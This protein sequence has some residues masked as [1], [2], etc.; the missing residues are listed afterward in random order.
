M[1]G[2]ARATALRLRARHPDAAALDAVEQGLADDDEL[3]QLA[4]LEALDAVPVPLR[5]GMA[6]SF[7]THPL[8]AFRITAA[9][10]LVGARQQLSERRR[11]D[12]AAALDEYIAVQAFNGDRAEGPF[13]RGNLLAADGRFDEA[14]AAF[15]A[16][17]EREPAFGPAHANLADLYR[18]QG[19]E[20]DAEAA[21]RRGLSANADDPALHFALGLSLVRSGRLDDALAEL[22]RAAV[23]ADEPRY[24]YAH[25]IALGS[26]G[27]M[28]QA[29]DV[30]TE[31]ARRFPG[32]APTLFALAALHRDAGN[33]GLALDYAQRML[34]VS[35]SDA[36]G[37]ALKAQLE[38]AAAT[39]P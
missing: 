28:E 2:I 25:G 27:R 35:P 30:L 10:G 31:A 1:P 13:N 21:L 39:A 3:V 11:R 22:R 23:G 38:A 24:A 33:A 8:R 19:R 29:L 37:R 20:A 36:D 16:A 6:Q 7:L 26:A 34:E 15:R 12:L 17:I 18:A 32:H 14:E 9:I 5:A 4:A